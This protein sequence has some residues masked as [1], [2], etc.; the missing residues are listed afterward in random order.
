[1]FVTYTRP[2]GGTERISTADLSAK[3]GADLEMVTDLMWHDIETALQR[4]APTALRAVLWIARRREEPGLLFSNFDVPQYQRRLKATMDYD[5]VYETVAEYRQAALDGKQLEMALRY[6]RKIADDPA[7]VDKA[8]AE[9]TP[10]EEPSHAE[11][12]PEESPA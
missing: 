6:T 2:D 1:M 12:A 7:D 3:E 8:L 9:T 10:K 4:Q 5:E 11:T